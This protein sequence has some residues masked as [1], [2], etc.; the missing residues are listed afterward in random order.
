[1]SL[2]IITLSFSRM[3]GV[4]HKRGLLG[5]AK[6]EEDQ[7]TAFFRPT[8][9]ANDLSSSSF[10]RRLPSNNQGRKKVVDR[11]YDEQRSTS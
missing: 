5:A 6:E 11:T 10:I 9:Y 1:M 8:S 4:T 3:S 2:G 7:T